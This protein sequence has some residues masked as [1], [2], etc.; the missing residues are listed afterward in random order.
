MLLYSQLFFLLGLGVLAN[1]IGHAVRGSLGGTQF[2]LLLIAGMGLFYLGKQIT[3]YMVF[4][5]Y[6]KNILINSA[7]CIAVTVAGTFLGAPAYA[8]I[9][10][11]AGMIFY[12]YSNFRWTLTKDTTAFHAAE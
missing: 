1:V 12:S 11:T 9:A 10:A 8:L 2:G 7:V 5:P 6:R 3:Y 4:P